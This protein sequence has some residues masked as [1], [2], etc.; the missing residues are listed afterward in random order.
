MKVTAALLMLACTVVCLAQQSNRVKRSKIAVYSVKDK[1][2]K[3]IYES[4]Q[5]IEE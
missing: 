2:V 4:D 3:T 1:S 5:L